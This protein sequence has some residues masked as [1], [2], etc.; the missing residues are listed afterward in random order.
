MQS[1][2]P[3]FKLWKIMATTYGGRLFLLSTIQI[4]MQCRIERGRCTLM[5]VTLE[6]LLLYAIVE[7][8]HSDFISQNTCTT[9]DIF[10]SRKRECRSIPIKL[11]GPGKWIIENTNEVSRYES[12][13]ENVINFALGC[14]EFRVSLKVKEKRKCKEI[15]SKASMLRVGASRFAFYYFRDFSAEKRGLCDA[16]CICAFRRFARSDRW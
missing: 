14:H 1:P 16:V 6:N 13:E 9:K 15:T 10:K 5:D 3:V 7:L 4:C 8:R 11:K 2:S 12:S